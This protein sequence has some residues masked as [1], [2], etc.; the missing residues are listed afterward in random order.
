[1]ETKR[2]QNIT[3]KIVELEYLLKKIT[4]KSKT[5]IS[6]LSTHLHKDEKLYWFKS[7]QLNPIFIR[8]AIQSQI[9]DY[10]RQIKEQLQV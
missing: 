5:D 2:L 10:K 3:N 7:M 4:T 9:N 8:E 6:V 1:M